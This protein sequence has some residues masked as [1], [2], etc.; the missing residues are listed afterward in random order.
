[1]KVCILNLMDLCICKTD[2]ECHRITYFSS[3]ASKVF[4][5][6]AQRVEPHSNI[7]YA[8][9]KC[10]HNGCER[11]FATKTNSSRHMERCRARENLGEEV[12]SIE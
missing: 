8:E 2:W 10:N 7:K 1:L 12:N 11:S 5:L 3:S 6:Y 4:I 9:Y